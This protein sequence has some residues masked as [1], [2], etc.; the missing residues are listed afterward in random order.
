MT[1]K[2]RWL[3]L[4][5]VLAGLVTGV[6]CWRAGRASAELVR[7]AHAAAH[8][9]EPAASSPTPAAS[10]A[11][12]AA[13]VASASA[14]AAPTAAS[15][16]FIEVCGQGPV[17]RSEIQPREGQPP[18]AWFEEMERQAKE[19]QAQLLK[20]LDAGSV[21]QRVAAALLREDTQG[22]AR[23][24]A[25]TD[26][27]MAYR[28]ALRACRK[29]AQYR[30]TY[31]YAASHAVSPAS[32]ASGFVIP[33]LPPPGA[34]PTGCAALTLERMEV[35]SPDDAW[36]ALVRLNDAHKRQDEAG[37]VQALYQLAQRP[38]KAYGARPLSD[39]LAEAVGAEPTMGET[40]Q[41]M[42][43]AQA[44][45]GVY[46]EGSVSDVLQACRPPQSDDANR[47]QLCEQVTRRLPEVTTELM[48]ARLLHRLEEVL[49]LPHS[50]QSISGAQL[51][52]AQE[53]L[54]K[55]GLAWVEEPT[56]ANVSRAGTYF[57]A[58]ARHGELAYARARL[59]ER[60]AVAAHAR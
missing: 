5:A 15:S 26:D 18:P 58:L 39:V 35:L 24:A 21:Q 51:D 50:R 33:E 40:S 12:A 27:A 29:D 3:V 19:T 31:A 16:P 4:V 55:D 17:L 2:W 53:A 14:S 34:Q 22:A 54:G 48:D 23:L 1:S 37:V 43:A 9:P 6:M 7:P 59:K 20:R 11:V 38:M 46:L 41:L 25:Q 28:L 47:R 30:A 36:P 42:M 60:G 10:V 57:A 45:M 49:S 13:L 52:R 8:A 32:V 44:D 56:C